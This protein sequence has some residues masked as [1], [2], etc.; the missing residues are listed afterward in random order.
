MKSIPLDES[1]NADHPPEFTPREL[2]LISRSLAE[3]RFV[4]GPIKGRPETRPS[5]TIDSTHPDAI[6]E[7]QRLYLRRVLRHLEDLSYDITTAI[8]NDQYTISPWEIARRTCR[9]CGSRNRDTAAYCDHCGHE[10]PAVP[11][12]P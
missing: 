3:L 6:R 8:R 2:R 4:S 5:R 11:R 1:G 10:L 12:T 9:Q 7:R